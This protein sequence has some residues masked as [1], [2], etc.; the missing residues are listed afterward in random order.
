[1]QSNHVRYETE[2]TWVSKTNVIN[3]LRCPYSFYL[4]ESGLIAYEDTISEQEA[5]LIERGTAFHSS[6]VA[7]AA[8]LTEY[9]DP[10]Q[11]SREESSRT[12]DIDLVKNHKLKIMG[13]PDAID[14]LKGELIPVEIK[15]HKNVQFSDKL[16][17]AFYWLLLEQYQTKR[18]ISP[19]GVLILRRNGR[20]EQVDVEIRPTHVQRVHRLHREIRD[21]RVNGVSPK[22][23]KCN[24]CTKAMADRIDLATGSLSLIS[25]MRDEHVRCLE[26]FDITN[27]EQLRTASTDAIVARFQEEGYS[28]TPH[29]VNGW[30][31]HATSYATGRIIVFGDPPPLHNGFLA[32]DLEYMPE[33]SFVWLIGVCIVD[34][35]GHEHFSF[36]ADNR[37]EEKSNLKQLTKLLSAN[38]SLPIV[39]W[40]GRTAD[41]P[42]LR[43]ATQQLKIKHLMNVMEPRHLDLREHF[44]K[45]V[46]IPWPWLGLK[47]VARVLGLTRANSIGGGLQ[48]LRLYHEYCTTRRKANRRELK[49][50]L[51]EYNRDDLNA[52]VGVATR[53]VSLQRT[54]A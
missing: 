16:E 26:E 28:V 47:D 37:S 11:L 25:Q 12:F 54:V 17:L 14:V 34:S 31:H 49:N 29:K 1:M 32:L 15:S 4:L 43:K 39:T 21:A 38:P 30:K 33:T 48:A 7:E 46:R 42:C 44:L 50:Q 22:K 45:A 10:Q 6:V 8:P 3:Y 9:A 36:W 13:K 23:C 52:L 5:S 35:S 41:V 51:L 18:T 27:Y 24:V 2:E 40:S 19:R 20:P 53:L